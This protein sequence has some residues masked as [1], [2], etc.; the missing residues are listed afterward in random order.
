MSATQAP[1]CRDDT[2]GDGTA[3]DWAQTWM[4]RWRVWLGTKSLEGRI[5]IVAGQ[6][7]L[8]LSSHVCMLE[9]S[10]VTPVQR[11]TGDFITSKEMGHLK[12]LGMLMKRSFLTIFDR[13]T[14]RETKLGEGSWL[15]EQDEREGVGGL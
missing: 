15:C 7:L 13:A 11:L 12:K 10:Y 9:R 3:E 14:Q 5:C 4:R 8:P 2:T 1:T 6:V